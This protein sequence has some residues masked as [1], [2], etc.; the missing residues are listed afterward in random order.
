MADVDLLIAREHLFEVERFLSSLGFPASNR[1]YF[2]RKISFFTYACTHA[3]TGSPQD[4]APFAILRKPFGI[5][6][7]GL[8][9]MN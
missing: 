6:R 3:S 8:I 1:W 2:R 5:M 4:F 7:L 9:G